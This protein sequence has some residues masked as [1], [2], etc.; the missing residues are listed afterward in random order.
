[1]SQK[2]IKI[3]IP[4]IKRLFSCSVVGIIL[5]TL[6]T[7]P[8]G[9]DIFVGTLCTSCILLINLISWIVVTGKIIATV[10][11]EA[12]LYNGEFQS[13]IQNDITIELSEDGKKEEK[14]QMLSEDD[15]HDREKNIYKPNTGGAT[16]FFMLKIPLLF[17]LLML[18][19]FVFSPLCIIFSNTI[20]VLSL[21]SSTIRVIW[22]AQKV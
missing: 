8:Q 20:I 21:L 4:G 6:F 12:L 1:M 13:Q 19:A 16:L 5:G 15:L 11:H 14:D 9:M 17:I 22:K 2:K 18:C 7:Y 10:R 3:Q